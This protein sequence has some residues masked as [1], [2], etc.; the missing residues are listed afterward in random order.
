LSF[1]TFGVGF[2][3]RPLGG[4]LFGVLGDPYGRKPVPVATLLMI[5]IGTVARVGAQSRNGI[6]QLETMPNCCDAKLLER[7]VRQARK[8]RFIYLIL[9]ERSLIL[10][11]AKAAQPTCDVHGGAPGSPTAA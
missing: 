9:A 7:L 5:G 8:E 10:P 3:V 1:L 4:L 11:K 6:E 2:V